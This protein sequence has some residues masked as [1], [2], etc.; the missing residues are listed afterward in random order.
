MI[1]FVWGLF[2][3]RQKAQSLSIKRERETYKSS[4]HKMTT[5]TNNNIKANKEIM[6]VQNEIVEVHITE[7]ETSQHR[8]NKWPFRLLSYKGITEIPTHI[9]YVVPTHI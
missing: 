1:F 7:Q 8:A 5:P 6:S 2:Q 9:Y 4:L 3:N